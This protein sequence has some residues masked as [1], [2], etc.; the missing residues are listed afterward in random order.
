MENSFF[1]SYR[2]GFD[3]TRFAHKIGV[4]AKKTEKPATGSSK[5]SSTGKKRNFIQNLKDSYTIVKR[6]FPWV[7]WAIL[8]T[9]VVVIGAN[10]VYM[11]LTKSWI[12]GAITIVMLLI[13]VP[14]AWLSLLISKAMLRQIERVKGSVGAL[15]QIIRR[16][17]VPETEPVA[18]N[19]EQ[20]LVWRFVGPQ[21][22][23]LISE[24]PHSRVAKLL[25][26]ETKKTARVASQVPIH[27]IEC[28][29]DDGQVRLEKVLKT[30]YKFPKALS[31][32]EVPAV[33]KRLKALHRKDGLPIPKGIDPTK[34]R[35]NRRALY[36]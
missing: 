18:F 27:T 3:L 1:A 14:M 23:L 16:S 19:K 30:A 4:M 26:D 20:D 6:S 29:F 2:K 24:G 7:T 8:G 36:G 34:I 13:L 32:N 5:G 9:L 21:G 10:V 12:W 11:I 33:V 35:P 22:I 17:W 25:A 28:G 31:R 15:S